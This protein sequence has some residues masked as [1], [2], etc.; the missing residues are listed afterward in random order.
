MV[1]KKILYVGLSSHYTEGTTYQDQELVMQNIQDGHAVVYVSD[2]NLYESGVLRV[3][4][5]EIKKM[6][7][8]ATLIRPKC[9]YTNTVSV[10]RNYLSQYL[11]FVWIYK[12]IN[13]ILS[14]MDPHIIY[15]HN[16]TIPE[17]C[18]YIKIKKKN[19]D[20]KIYYDYHID[21]LNRGVFRLPK[22]FMYFLHENI[23]RLFLKRSLDSVEKIFYI[24][25]G[26]KQYIST[27]YGIPDDMLEFLPLGGRVPDRVGYL[28]N[29]NKVR[30]DLQLGDDIIL[31]I[32]TGKLSS[33]KR[34]SEIINAFK[35]VDNDK[36]RLIILGSIPAEQ[37]DELSSLINSDSRIQYLG[38][39]TGSEL[40]EYLCASDVYIQLGSASATMQNALCCGCPVLLNS[41]NGYYNE[42][43][44]G[45]G[46]FV[47]DKEELMDALTLISENPNV[48]ET[49]KDATWKIASEL[50]DYKK[51]AARIY[52]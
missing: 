11:R 27:N 50:L 42:F 6:K 33:E 9:M 32:H 7:C 35:S 14:E 34:T 15:S 49:M 31:F 30:K 41:C 18:S 44:R 51:I 52:E 13:H 37:E 28:C 5:P 25:G 26:T 45:N 36:F 1:K 24:W 19:P 38:W 22:I 40:Q 39:K 17:I 2:C 21:S 4:E 23:Y 10:F 47:N 8:G 12:T 3:T 43:M 48:L 46:M 29:R 20:V 16:P